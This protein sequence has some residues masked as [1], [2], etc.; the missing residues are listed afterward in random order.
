MRPHALHLT[1]TATP[2]SPRLSGLTARPVAA[3]RGV[4]LPS[5][6]RTG[7]AAT[8]G[9]ASCLTHPAG[10]PRRRVGPALPASARR[11]SSSATT[12]RTNPLGEVIARPTP[13]GA[14]RRAA[15]WPRMTTQT[16]TAPRAHPRSTPRQAQSAPPAPPTR[17]PPGQAKARCR[18]ADT[19]TTTRSQRPVQTEATH[20]APPHRLSSPDGPSPG[21]SDTVVVPHTNK[22]ETN[23]L[24]LSRRNR[25]PPPPRRREH[26]ARAPRTSP[27]T[28][29]RHADRPAGSPSPTP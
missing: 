26:S 15:R 20:A 5:L 17:P 22:L 25:R 28:A 2:R 27:P 10:T 29:L 14:R 7:R 8:T 21:P 18:R 12:D 3:T 1:T 4:P 23:I 9:T 6:R 11:R 13:A 24:K 16:A 19:P